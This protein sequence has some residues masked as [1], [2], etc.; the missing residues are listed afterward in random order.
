M[1]VSD[2]Q[3]DKNAGKCLHWC[4]VQTDSGGSFL[5]IDSRCEYIYLLLAVVS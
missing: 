4:F 2:L 1:G 3:F 5:F